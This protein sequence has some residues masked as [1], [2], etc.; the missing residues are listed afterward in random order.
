MLARSTALRDG[1]WCQGCGGGHE[2]EVAR[3]T[4][5]VTMKFVDGFMIHA[6]QPVK[7]YIDY[8]VRHVLLRQGVLGIK[9]KIMRDSDAKGDQWT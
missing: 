1:I 7:D 2:R 5:K 9:V 6:G 8:A 3:S 4:C